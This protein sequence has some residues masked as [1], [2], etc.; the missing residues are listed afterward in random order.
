MYGH[1][2]RCV[3][4]LYYQCELCKSTLLDVVLHVGCITRSCCCRLQ[5]VRRHLPIN[6]SRHLRHLHDRNGAV[7]TCLYLSQAVQAV[8]TS[9]I[10]SRHLHDR[11]GAVRTCLY[12]S[13]AVQA[14]VMSRSRYVKEKIGG[15]SRRSTQREGGD[16]S[17][18]QEDRRT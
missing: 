15:R 9:R 2:G 12:L 18:T 8:V 13:Q 14:V 7:R 6:H 5:P 10:C 11:N 4:V 16:A 17:L 3:L 1:L